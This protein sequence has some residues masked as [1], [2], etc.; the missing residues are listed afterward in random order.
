MSPDPPVITQG[1]VLV[2]TEDRDIEIECVSANG[3]P[4]AEV[5]SI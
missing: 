5:C 1:D 3:K 2:T 4:A